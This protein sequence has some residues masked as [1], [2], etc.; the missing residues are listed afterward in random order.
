MKHATILI[1]ILLSVGG[2]IGFWLVRT[3]SHPEA[4]KIYKPAPYKPRQEQTKQHETPTPPIE[5]KRNSK[6][7]HVK[8]L[9][10][11]I[12]P[13]SKRLPGSE[14][15]P[16]EEAAFLEWLST[17]DPPSSSETIIERGEDVADQAPDT[18]IPYAELFRIVRETYDLKEV[19]NSYWLMS[20]L[21]AFL[22]LNKF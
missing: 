8:R 20:S 19:I 4:I 9:Q 16:E 17:L 14:L 3:N 15:S 10:T 6:R 13:E 12:L 18:S 2:L 21:N 5:G 1:V 22:C 7:E 11:G